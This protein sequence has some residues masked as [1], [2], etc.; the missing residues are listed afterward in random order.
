MLKMF[1]KKPK[2]QDIQEIIQKTDHD[3]SGTL[4]RNF[5]LSA[6]LG[7]FG[8]AALAEPA[9]AE[10]APLTLDDE[11]SLL[12]RDRATKTA[13][14]LNEKTAVFHVDDFALPK[15]AS[16]SYRW[17]RAVDAAKAYTTPQPGDNAPRSAVVRGGA[18]TYLLGTIINCSGIR[19]TVIEGAGE[20]QTHILGMLHVT[21]SA[22]FMFLPAGATDAEDVIFRNLNFRG[23]LQPAGLIAHQRDGRVF[24]TEGSTTMQVTKTGL[25]GDARGLMSA[26]LPYGSRV[27]PNDPTRK[28]LRNVIIENC[29]FWGLPSLPVIF[30]GVDGSAVFRDNFVFRCLDVGFTYNESVIC[31]GNRVEWSA[32][33]GISLSR[34][35][36]R[37]L[38]TSN[39]IY[40]SYFNG[41]WATGYTPGTVEG[42]APIPGTAGPAAVVV[43]GNIIDF[44]AMHGVSV[45]NG[46]KVMTIS[47]NTVT[48]TR[49]IKKVNYSGLPYLKADGVGIFVQGLEGDVILDDD[50]DGFTDFERLA[51][52]LNITGNTITD[53]DRGGIIIEGGHN[54][55][56]SS[57]LIVRP[58]RLKGLNN[59][60]IST[61]NGTHNVG[62]SSPGDSAN[63]KNVFVT[64]NLIV[65]DRTTNGTIAPSSSRV[66]DPA[67]AREGKAMYYGVKAGAKSTN[68]VYY[69]NNVVGSISPYVEAAR[70]VLGSNVV[71]GGTDPTSDSVLTFDHAHSK[72]GLLVFS[73]NKIPRFDIL[74]RGRDVA[75]FGKGDWVYFRG[76]SI[77]GVKQQILKMNLVTGQVILD[78]PIK[79]PIAAERPSAVVYGPGAMFY[80]QKLRK[81]IFSDGTVWR[82]ADGLLAP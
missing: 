54:I 37:V 76:Y 65:D 55:L 6:G 81:P 30:A 51:A 15:D 53:A 71:V 14:Q 21:L 41:I 12:L 20:N 28:S 42:S 66:D 82:T 25:P 62:I 7:T 1:K 63:V 23:S 22:A 9:R 27:R 75:D 34:G 72:Q 16:D 43:M 39:N 31:T 77:D 49:R 44:S 5:I 19:N 59:D 32:D 48:N 38:A 61:N 3:S 78:K 17:Q 33:N 58:G 40:G 50:G 70:R 29:H 24:A 57:N 26:I 52:T 10:D 8:V 64:G 74:H 36:D 2:H 68:W 11:I 60:A 4:R 13:Q 80:D 79:L 18:R 45:E 46:G 67:V 35:N 73:E 69:D 56:V 47:G